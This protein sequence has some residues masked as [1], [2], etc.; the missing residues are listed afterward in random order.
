M[1]CKHYKGGGYR[2]EI[3][4]EEELLLCSQCNLNLAGELSKQMA[5]GVFSEGIIRNGNEDS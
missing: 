5:I 3:S 2:Y 1:K 4:E